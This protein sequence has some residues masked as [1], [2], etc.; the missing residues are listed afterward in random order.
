MEISGF[1]FDSAETVTKRCIAFARDGNKV[2]KPYKKLYS[3]VTLTGNLEHDKLFLEVVQWSSCIMYRVWEQLT[4]FCICIGSAPEYATLEDLT[5]GLS[6][7]KFLGIE[8]YL[9]FL[10]E[11]EKFGDFINLVDIEVCRMLRQDG[12]VT[13]YTE[14]RENFLREREE[15]EAKEQ[16]EREQKEQEEKARKAAERE[17]QLQDAEDLIRKRQTLRN[18]KMEDGS[19]LVLVLMKRH[20]VQVPLRT[21]GWINKAL[22]SITFNQG[23][24]SYQYYSSSSDSKVFRQYLLTMQ[25]RIGGENCCHADGD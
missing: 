15:K 24:I 11:K 17:K 18:E 8:G 7:Y 12:L 4:D 23:T 5:K 6:G 2:V 3:F 19:S 21:Q 25:E 1:N 13:H 22:H 14:Y 9:N 16:A 20:G 10:R